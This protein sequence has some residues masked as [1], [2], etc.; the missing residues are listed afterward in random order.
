MRQEQ[1]QSLA[2][3]VGV[4]NAALV[5]LNL[6]TDH[7]AQPE[8]RL[9][10]N[11]DLTQD[12][13]PKVKGLVEAFGK[14][15]APVLYVNTRDGGLSNDV[16]EVDPGDNHCFFEKTN[17]SA[18]NPGVL[19]RMFGRVTD[20]HKYLKENEVNTLVV[21]GASISEDVIKTS[22]DGL[23]A[24]YNVVVVSDAIGNDLSNEHEFPGQY[25]LSIMKD[26]GVILTTTDDVTEAISGGYS[27]DYDAMEAAI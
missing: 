11:N 10:M 22:L 12:V 20:V 7:F 8:H 19:G 21:V 23:R 4:D 27:S 18:L 6:H 3:D 1:S 25:A 26:R 17:S 24:R 15:C 16:I 2:R 9:G 13:L 14:V 5:V